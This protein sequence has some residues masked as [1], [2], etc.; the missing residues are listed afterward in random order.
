M[1]GLY[2]LTIPN[3][4]LKDSK[5]QSFKLKVLYGTNHQSI[6]WKWRQ[7]QVVQGIARGTEVDKSF[8]VGM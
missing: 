8:E 4:L 1:E 2:E 3:P 5:T 6:G 7:D